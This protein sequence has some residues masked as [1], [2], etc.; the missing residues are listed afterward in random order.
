[1]TWR[2]PDAID[3]GRVK[4]LATSAARALAPG[5]HERETALFGCQPQELASAAVG[6]HVDRTVLKD[7][8]VAN[9]LVEIH[10]QRLL[11]D[12]LV[13]LPQLE[14]EDRLAGQAADEHAGLPLWEEIAAIERQPGRR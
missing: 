4:R 5:H 11:V 8:H 14:T 2:P 6:Q 9:P 10:E 1:M 12:D 7:A 3:D 13:V